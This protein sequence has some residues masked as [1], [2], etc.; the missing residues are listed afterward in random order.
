MIFISH[1]VKTVD[2]YAIYPDDNSYFIGYW[3]EK[4]EVLAFSFSEIK[5]LE[6]KLDHFTIPSDFNAEVYFD[7]HMHE[8]TSSFT[9]YTVELLLDKEVGGC[10]RQWSRTEVVKE[11]SDG[12]IYVKFAT[13]EILKVL[14]WILICGNTVK[15]VG[16]A[17]LV[18]MVQN[19]MNEVE[20][21]G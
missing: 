13:N 2:P 8:F 16:P 10:A 15:V 3:H 20:M 9:S 21:H 19:K 4:K 12:S 6:L 17:V 18:K 1:P 11:C 5:E 7:R 14:D